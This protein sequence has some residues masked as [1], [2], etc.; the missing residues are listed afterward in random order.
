M[1]EVKGEGGRF[2]D[3]ECVNGLN[4]AQTCE[5]TAIV[6]RQSISG[7]FKDPCFLALLSP[8]HEAEVGMR[9]AYFGW[10]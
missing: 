5:Y 4:L 9:R 8:S 2:R 6:Y 1:E 3:S 10:M 7:Y